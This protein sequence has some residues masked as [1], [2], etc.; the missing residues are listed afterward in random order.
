MNRGG[1]RAQGCKTGST[2]DRID[3]LM[4]NRIRPKETDWFK[5]GLVSLHGHKIR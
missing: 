1:T 5:R 4:A 2:V 3:G